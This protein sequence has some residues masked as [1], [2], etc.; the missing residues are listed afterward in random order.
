[1][2]EWAW[3]QIRFCLEKYRKFEPPCYIV[4]TSSDEFRYA[5]LLEQKSRN[6]ETPVEPSWTLIDGSTATRTRSVCVGE[7]NVDV[8][9]DQPCDLAY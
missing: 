5:K 7:M 1:M 6:Q 2:L 4:L 9:D 8:C 3:S